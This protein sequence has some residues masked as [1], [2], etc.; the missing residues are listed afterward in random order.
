[1]PATIFTD[2]LQYALTCGVLVLAQLVYVLFGFGSGLVALGLLALIFPDL[3]DPVVLLLLVNL[4]TELTISWRARRQVRWR[5]IV[6]IGAGVA[7]GIVVGTRILQTADTRLAVTVLGWFLVVVGLVFLRLPARRGRD[8]PRW[9]AV[10]TG[11]IAGVLNGLFGAGGPPVIIWYHL[12]AP[13][14]TAFRGSLMTLFFLMGL[15]RIPVYAVSGLVTVPRLVSMVTVI[16]AVV[17]GAWLGNR[18]HLQLSEPAFRK[19]VAVAL[20]VLGAMLL[21]RG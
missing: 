10:P 16:P 3:K 21:I 20:A 9:L 6:L 19:L 4:P 1:M 14:K 8:L 7:V 18:I 13:D 15:V 2:P 12:T 5:P 17:V 11:L